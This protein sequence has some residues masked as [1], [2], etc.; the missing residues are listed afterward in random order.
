MD[1]KQGRIGLKDL[2]LL[3]FLDFNA[4]APLSTFSKNVGLSKQSIDYRI[5]Q[6]VKKGI[7]EGFYPVI[8]THQLGYIYCRILVQFASLEPQDEKRLKKYI[9][10]SKN[11][12]WALSLG[13]AF[14]YLLIF[15]V[16]NLSEFENT[17]KEFQSR[18]GRLILKKEEHVITNVVH[19]SHKFFEGKMA[20]IRFDLKET[21]KRHELDELDK[22]IL[23]QLA[24]EAR[25]SLVEISKS[26]GISP[27]VVSYRIKKME[28]ENFIAGYRPIINYS[29]LGLTYYK[30]FFNLDF[31]AVKEI[32][33]FEKFLLNNQMVI[34]IVHGIAI[35]G[36]FDVEVLARSNQDFFEFIKGLRNRFPRLISD[37]TY[38]IYTG[39]I[40]VNYLP[41]Y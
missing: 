28:K 36:N 35:H 1:K 22:K 37:Y 27:K 16:K 26:T 14:D 8:N 11:L 29:K 7:I 31:L 34:Y 30:V 33:D 41:F 3:S 18:F 39:T 20:R 2:K 13:G 19:L 10:E 32:E 38:L 4:R 24:I 5:S 17:M 25:T 21:E 6:L 15:W 40:K 12:F 9:F 23:K